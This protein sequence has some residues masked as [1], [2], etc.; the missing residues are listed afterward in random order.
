MCLW[1]AGVGVYVEASH[2]VPL[3]PISP[4]LGGPD[5]EWCSDQRKVCGDAF[6]LM[7]L[8]ET[9]SSYH[10]LNMIMNCPYFILFI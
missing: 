2:V 7:F 3:E 6:L 1:A 5:G 4:P 9:G 8:N 10:F